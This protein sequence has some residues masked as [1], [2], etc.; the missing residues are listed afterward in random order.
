MRPLTDKKEAIRRYKIPKKRKQLRSFLGFANYYHR[1][2]RN[3]S[4]VVAPLTDMTKGKPRQL[5]WSEQAMRA[6]K[7]V[8][9]LLCKEPVLYTSK[10]QEPFYLQTDVS[11]CTMAAVLFHKV[12][13][14]EKPITYASKKF[15]KAETRYSTIERECLAIRWGIELFHY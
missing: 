2:I 1:C 10:F 9:Y 8:K 6:F 11:G 5:R 14:E 12:Q 15:S 3:F 13:G 7:E 4:E